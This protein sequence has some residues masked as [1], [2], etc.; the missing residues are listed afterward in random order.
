M[1]PDQIAKGGSEHSTQAALFAFCT[2]A[3]MHGFAAAWAWAVGAALP[4]WTGVDAIPELRWY[5]AVPNGANYGDDERGSRITGGKM[6]AEG[7]RK[8]V[9]DTFLPVRRVWA[10]GLYI[11]MKKPSLKSLKDKLAGC[12]D[13]QKSFGAFVQQQGFIFE[14]CYTWREAAEILQRYLEW[15]S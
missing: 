13:E 11:E 12:S 14:V 8:G 10:S 1:L 2:V 7:L 3:A 4:K 9:S 5:H 15:K 6:K